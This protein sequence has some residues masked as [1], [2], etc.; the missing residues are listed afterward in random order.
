M[1]SDVAW[2]IINQEKNI[3]NKLNGNAIN[4]YVFEHTGIYEIN[5]ADNK[6]HKE[7]DCNHATFD[8]KMLIKVSDVKMRFD[9]SK[10]KF[11]EKIRTGN[12]CEGIIVTVPVDV[13]L[14]QNRLTKFIPSQFMV[15]G[16]G[17]DIIA[18]PITQDIGLK[19]GTFV[20]QYKLFGTATKETYLM[21]DFIDYNNNVQ[22]YNQT[23]LV[24]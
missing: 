4:D 11:S 18:K 20:L 24:N 15:A 7:G 2:T 5:Y 19:T 14:K 23:E 6:K 1:D 9:F 17:S 22:T 16:V 21:F 13:I 3:S 12:N 8:S 10:I